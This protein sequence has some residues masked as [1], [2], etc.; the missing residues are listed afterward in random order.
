MSTTIQIQEETRD[1]IKSFGLKGE[2]YDDIINRLFEKAVEQQLKEFLLS[3][4]KMIPID[5]AIERSNKK[6]QK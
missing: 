3:S 5:E 1:K 6:W 2:T 4:D